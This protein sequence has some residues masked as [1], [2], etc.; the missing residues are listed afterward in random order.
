MKGE[1][2]HYLDRLGEPFLF[3]EERIVTVTTAKV[4]PFTNSLPKILFVIEGTVFH[5]FEEGR[6]ERLQA[7]DVLI[8]LGAFRQTYLPGPSSRAARI[9]VL[10]LTF[11]DSRDNEFARKILSRLPRK[12]I[13]AC[14]LPV[15]VAEIRSELRNRRR[16]SRQ[17]VHALARAALIDVI[18]TLESGSDAGRARPD[19][20]ERL[21]EAIALHL[22]NHLQSP[23]TLSDIARAVDRSEEHIARV[24]RQQRK[25]TIFA[26]LQRMRIERARYL[27]LCS[28]L[29]K[30][31]ISRQCGFSTPAHFSRIFRAHTGMSPS[32]CAA[33]Y[34]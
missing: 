11:P 25:R 2:V 23:I 34:R 10:R 26:E 32:E 16:D 9:R 17:R 28:E 33:Q 8:N 31:A 27:L 30:T 7:G 19:T 3:L 21:S 22:E 13:A 6:P 24:F 12:G 29:S 15:W 1:V 4:H 20:A 18:R 5:R 14:P